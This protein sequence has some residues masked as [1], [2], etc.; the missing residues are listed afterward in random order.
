MAWVLLVD[1]DQV[2]RETL[3]FVLQDAGYDVEEAEDGM[4]AVDILRATPHRLV[5]LLDLMMPRVSGAMVL[6]TVAADPRLSTQ[7]A[8]ILMTA[9]YRAVDS[10]LSALLTRLADPVLDKPFDLDALL[11]AVAQAAKRL[12]GV[13]GVGE[14]RSDQP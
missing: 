12:N 2:L 14:H 11:H 6:Q 5:V 13:N 10:T 4:R 1:D 3:R 8:Y 9:N 7:H